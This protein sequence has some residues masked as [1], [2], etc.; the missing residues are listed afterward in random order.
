MF[1]LMKRDI[2]R[3]IFASIK[4]KKRDDKGQVLHNLL[5]FRCHVQYATDP[6]LRVAIPNPNPPEE[7]RGG[8]VNT[9]SKHACESFLQVVF[10]E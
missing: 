5:A 1:I 10:S 9:Y 2:M 3:Q 8:G 7:K 4:E 6:T